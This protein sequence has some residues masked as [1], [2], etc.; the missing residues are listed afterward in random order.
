[1]AT[2]ALLALGLLAGS[3]T[4]GEDSP[5]PTS[6]TPT[7]TIA[8]IEG[9]TNSDGKLSEF[10]KQVLAR[11]APRDITLHDGTA[12]TVTPGQPLPQS[13]IAQIAADAAPGVAQAQSLD[14]FEPFAGRR[15]ILGVAQSYAEKLSRTVGVVF[16][17]GRGTWGTIISDGDAETDLIGTSDK[18]AA[19]AAATNW[20]ASHDAY[21]VVVD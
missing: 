14:E 7:P 2:A 19:I 9:D 10:E 13:V 12:A 11:N 4:V 8:P 17:D 21:M 5:Q 3:S 15:S 18:D 6:A 16:H 20:A 1:M